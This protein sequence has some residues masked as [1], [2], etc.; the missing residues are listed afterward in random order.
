MAIYKSNNYLLFFVF[1]V[2][3]RFLYAI[4]IEKTK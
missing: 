4:I 2:L 1:F 3:I